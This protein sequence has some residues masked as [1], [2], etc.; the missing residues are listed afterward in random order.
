MAKAKGA[1]EKLSE[2]EF[3]EV[4]AGRQSMPCRS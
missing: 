4:A 1:V 2:R 3:E